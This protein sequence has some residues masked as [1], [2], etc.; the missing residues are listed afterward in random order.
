M[1][2][3]IMLNYSMHSNN[4]SMTICF[5]YVNVFRKYMLQCALN[6]ITLFMSYVYT[7]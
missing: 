3:Y 6:L 1:K 4:S 2:E 7:G 5:I